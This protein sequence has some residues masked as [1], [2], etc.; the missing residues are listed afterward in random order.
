MSPPSDQIFLTIIAAPKSLM[1]L[2]SIGQC[3]SSGT[4]IRRSPK[5]RTEM[6]VRSGI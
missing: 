3:H 2:E 5:L 4:S 1:Y 6:T